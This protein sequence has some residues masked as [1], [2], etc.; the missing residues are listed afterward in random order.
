[1]ARKTLLDKS[2]AGHAFLVPESSL[3][4][5]VNNRRR[6]Y[7]TSSRKFTDTTFGGHFAI[8]PLSQFTANCD[9]KHPSI[10]TPSKGMGRWYSEVLDD[11][12]QLIHIR[13]GVPQFNSMTSFFAN[14]Y[15]V[16]A[17]AVVRTGRG[18]DVWFRLGQVAGF[19]GTVPLQPFILAG[20]AIK[21]FTG[22]P[23]SKYYYL[24]PTM[25]PY[26]FAVS[27][28][29]NGI[30]VNLGL[31]P[32]FV[33][34]EQKR[35]YDP[36]VIPGD[37]DIEEMRRIYGRVMG[38][39]GIDVFALSNKAQRLANEYRAAIDKAMEGM[40][41][42]PDRRADELTRLLFDGVDRVVN[43]IRDPGASLSDYEKAYL[44]FGGAYQESAAYSAEVDDP[45]EGFWSNAAD[46]FHSERKM[47]ADFI[48]FRVNN[49]G[50]QSESFSNK[51]GESSLQNEINGI[52]A[53]AR[54]ARFSIADGNVTDTLGMVFDVV[55]SISA[56]ILDMAQLEG[57]MA[58]AGNA[59]ADIQ[60]VYESSSADLN[61]T[62]FTIPLR[63]WAAD[64]WV[65]LKNLYLPL[66]AIMAMGLPRA[67]GPASYDGPFLLEVYNQG[68]T[69]IRE[70]MVESISIERGVGDIGW[71]RGGKCL[72]IDV[73]VNIVDLSNVLSVPIN[74]AVSP[75]EGTIGNVAS[76]IG[77]GVGE[78]VVAALSKSTYGEDNKFT[79]YL[80]T[81]AGLPL[82][83]QI[84]TTRKWKLHMARTRANI[85]QWGSSARLVSML[86]DTLPGDIIK[87]VSMPTA[88]D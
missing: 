86:F 84:N 44:A 3:T 33:P 56:G 40:S 48:T 83:Y 81:L 4:D 69:Q 38:E 23:R 72:G 30:M 26:W 62:S 71:G 70:G 77:G 47:G 2:W 1:M 6:Y 24:K 7:T 16:H 53:K 79:D 18:P 61:R 65:R 64:D 85:D 75:I 60:Q 10:Y 78:T 17:G 29:L 45:S 12:S 14:F 35:F 68:R 58:I 59:F 11:N 13:C 46:Y 5:S 27:N 50:T 43:D 57:F 41:D 28:I 8:N 51:T 88:R 21:F 82:E 54:Q 19:I 66:A 20:S 37:R 42:D 31:T 55:K 36:A 15:N 76:A 73:T 52:S 80:A 32:H 9:F 87:A 49:T 34:G 25:Y 67:T 22:A 39:S 74:P 63:S